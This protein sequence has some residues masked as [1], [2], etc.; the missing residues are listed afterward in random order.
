VISL[1]F[2]STSKLISSSDLHEQK[3]DSPITSTLDGMLILFKPVSAKAK[4]PIRCNLDFGSNITSERLFTI[5][6]VENSFLQSLQ[7]S[8]ELLSPSDSNRKLRTQFVAAL[9]LFQI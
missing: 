1:S 3:Q 6:S 9:I 4:H 8:M 5:Y 7:H 2:E